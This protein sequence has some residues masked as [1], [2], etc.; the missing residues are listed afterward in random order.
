MLHSLSFCLWGFQPL[1]PIKML[2]PSYSVV[3]RG[4]V[5]DSPKQL[6]SAS[7]RSDVFGAGGI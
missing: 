6:A 5:K 4:L 3:S 1:L 7:A 2:R